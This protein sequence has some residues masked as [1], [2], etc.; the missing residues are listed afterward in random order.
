MTPT[1]IAALKAHTDGGDIAP[2]KQGVEELRAILHSVAKQ[3]ASGVQYD[4]MPEFKDADSPV[5]TLIAWQ[6][7]YTGGEK[8]VQEAEKAIAQQAAAGLVEHLDPPSVHIPMQQSFR[9]DQV[10][11]QDIADF[12]L[13]DSDFVYALQNFADAKHASLVIPTN[14]VMQALSYTIPIEPGDTVGGFAMTPTPFL[15]MVD[16][17]SDPRTNLIFHRWNQ[18]RATGIQ[19]RARGATVATITDA[20]ERVSL[21]KRSRAGLQKIDLELG[22]ASPSMVAAE[23][24]RCINALM[25]DINA[26]AI[27]GDNT[28]NNWKGA[29][30]DVTGEAVTGTPT[31][32]DELLTQVDALIDAGYAPNAIFMRSADYSKIRAHLIG[33]NFAHPDLVMGGVRVEGVRCVREASVPANT[34]VIG[35]FNSMTIRVEYQDGISVAVSEEAAFDTNQAAL[36][37][38]AAGNIGVIDKYAFKKLTN[39]GVAT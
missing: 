18:A 27:N 10:T 6:E 16:Q 35:E 28:G 29:V 30:S 31:L 20:T 37:V 26:Q 32:Y 21:E 25:Y 22:V 2:V 24:P 36:R 12:A 34:V 9:N 11:M 4:S 39:T 3:N 23:T 5:E 19:G 13:S 38:V 15:S 17:I 1:L 7:A 33:L 8:L 14:M